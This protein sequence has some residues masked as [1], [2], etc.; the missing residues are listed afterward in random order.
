[1]VITAN[2]KRWLDGLGDD[3]VAFDQ[4]GRRLIGYDVSEADKKFVLYF[5]QEDPE[6]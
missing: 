1:M 5:D 4:D 6:K 2:I 3:Y